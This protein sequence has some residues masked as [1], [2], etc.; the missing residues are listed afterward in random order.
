MECQ[1]AK[2]KIKTALLEADSNTKLVKIY[3]QGFSH[4]HFL[5]T[6]AILVRIW[7]K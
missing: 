4:I 2:K 5:V 7:S 1:I 6:E 3:S